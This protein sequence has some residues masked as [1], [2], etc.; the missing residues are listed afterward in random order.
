MVHSLIESE[1]RETEKLNEKPEKVEKCKELVTI[2]KEWKYITRAKKK[3][4]SAL[5]TTK[6]QIYQI[7]QKKSLNF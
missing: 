3:N 2:I 6:N 5:H 7:H 1:K 4:I